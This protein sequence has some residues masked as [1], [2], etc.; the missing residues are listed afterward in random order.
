[1]AL[2][3]YICGQTQTPAALPQE[4]NPIPLI[5]E[6][7]WPLRPVWADPENLAPTGI[8][9][10]ARPANSE[11]LYLLHTFVYVRQNKVKVSRSKR[12][13]VDPTLWT[14]LPLG[15]ACVNYE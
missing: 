15:S 2:D 7:G 14:A 5:Q 1:M 10:P 11:S 8:R 6:A 9:S 13:T 4:K 12:K 3:G